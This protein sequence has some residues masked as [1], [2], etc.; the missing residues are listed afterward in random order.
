M[1]KFANNGL[2]IPEQVWDKKEVP[3]ADSQFS[4]NLQFGE[5]TGSA[6]PLAWS[7]AQ[8]IRLAVNL[9]EGKNLDTPDV[10]YERYVLGKKRE[11]GFAKF[12]EEIRNAL[13]KRCW[14]EGPVFNS[15]CSYVSTIAEE[16]SQ[17]PVL[18]NCRLGGFFI[19]CKNPSQEMHA[20]F[21][22]QGEFNTLE[23]AGDFTSWKPV[24]LKIR[25]QTDGRNW[26]DCFNFAKTARVE[27]KLIVD[28]KW[29]TDPLNPNKI[30]NGVG[31]ENSVLEMPDYKPSEW[32]K[33]IEK[34]P[35]FDTKPSELEIDSKKFGK[36]TV[37]IYV[38]S[39]YFKR[40]I[41]PKLPVLYL[42]D[43][44]DY[45]TR[46][47]AIN[48]L[49][50]LVT[51]K[52]VEPFMLV[53]IDPKDRMKEY[54]A[55]DDW[56]EFVAKEVVPTVEK[57]YFSTIKTGR[58]NRALLGASLGGITS[59]WTALKY[60]EMFANVGGQ[61][62]SF[63]VDDERVVKELAKLKGDEKFNFYIDDGTFEGVEDSQKVAKML[64]EKGFDVTY[65]EGETGHNWTSWRDRLADAFIALWKQ[66]K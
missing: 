6:T 32:A 29:I 44:S 65:I 40:G 5:G 26:I 30:D 56:A 24:P 21:N 66:S 12:T 3:E 53:F 62:S 54:W 61:S 2:M 35:L 10:V 18:R 8:F 46:G 38:P 4:P 64:R 63:W 33:D 52:K 50:R 48:V 34:S 9:Q 47:K 57:K 27:Y 31:G 22:Y 37:K 17:N 43:G 23:I 55:N 60:P 51:A 45:I 20:C 28:G 14:D 7:M 16:N 15:E 11:Y 13:N 41:A 49:E 36:R 42:Q 58:E 1:Q 59:I 19:A 25:K 39:E